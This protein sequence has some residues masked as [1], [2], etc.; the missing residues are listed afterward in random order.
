MYEHCIYMEVE[1]DKSLFL[2][3]VSSHL[4][5]IGELRSRSSQR[6]RLIHIDS[7]YLGSFFFSLNQ[8]E[9]R[10]MET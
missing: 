7:S 10:R 5:K 1:I 4:S 3:L 9:Y 6:K 2:E 8:H